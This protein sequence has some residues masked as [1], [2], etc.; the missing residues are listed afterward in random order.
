[1]RAVPSK[2]P[3]LW[4][5]VVPLA[6]VLYFHGMSAT[7]VL[8]PDEPRYASIGREMANSGDWI[9]PRLWGEPWFEKPALL[10]WMTGL[11]FRAGLGPDTAPRLPVALASLAFLIFFYAALRREFGTAAAWTS[12]LAL[13]TCAGWIGFSAVGVTDLPLAAALSVAMLLCLP[14]VARGDARAL[15]WASAWLGVA[16]LAKGLVPLVLAVPL[17]WMGRKNWRDLLHP[18]AW[19]PF[20]I[21]AVPWYWLCW[22][23]N[24][25]PFIRT[26]FLEHHFGRFTS[27]A[28][29]HGQPWWFY[30]PVLAG[31]LL[32]WTPLLIQGR[33]T[34]FDDARIRFLF[35]WVGFGLVFFSA[36]ANK[37][38]GYLLPLVPAA[39]ALAG[40]ALDRTRD[41][42]PWLAA[43]ALLLVVLPVAAQMLPAALANGLSRAPRPAFHWFWLFPIVLAA[44][45]WRMESAGRREMAVL[46][47][48]GGAAAGILYIKQTA[49]PGIEQSVSARPLWRSVA[50]RRDQV[51]VEDLHRNWRYGLNYY[52]VKPLPDCSAEPRPLHIQQT[53]GQAPA[54]AAGLDPH[55]IAVIPSHFRY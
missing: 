11:A 42:R 51:C 14:W 30:L 40:I 22:L 24:G 8:G 5:L 49:S 47:I 55:S 38:P 15:P 18:R 52:S 46:L 39:A 31:G 20:L 41:A 12:S 10:Y 6:Y 13:G 4:W 29:L 32:P 44:A 50:A 25:Y 43:C 54:V 16:V 23:R 2:L 28:L 45:A 3:R 17:L 1:M 7:G 37:L 36:A 19:L 21:V 26:F 27:T 34:L 35:L 48:A 53:P 9:T 33:R